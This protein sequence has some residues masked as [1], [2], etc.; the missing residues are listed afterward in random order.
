MPVADMIDYT[1][2]LIKWQSL[3]SCKEVYAAVDAL[4]ACRYCFWWLFALHT[5]DIS[6]VTVNRGTKLFHCSY[7]FHR[8]MHVV[9]SAILLSVVSRPSVP[10][11]L[12]SVCQGHS[13]SYL[14]LTVKTSREP[15]SKSWS[16]SWS[17]DYQS[18]K[19]DSW[20]FNPNLLF[21]AF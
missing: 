19:I 10:L 6:L 5:C 8:T 3:A 15:I 14:S 4:V 2:H 1:V 9:Q 17:S 13:R 20:I 12:L 18:W 21:W 7:C 11:S 16:W